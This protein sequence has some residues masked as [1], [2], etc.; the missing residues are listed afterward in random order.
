MNRR[1]Q[2]L[3]KRVAA[4]E[5]LSPLPEKDGGKAPEADV[6]TTSASVSSS[7][8]AFITLIVLSDESRAPNPARNAGDEIFSKTW[9]T[10]SP[11][12][13]CPAGWVENVSFCTVTCGTIMHSSYFLSP[14]VTLR[15][16]GRPP[17]RTSTA[18]ALPTVSLPS[19]EKRSSGSS[20]G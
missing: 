11:D 5:S 15:V 12:R 17:R 3:R 7:N 10:M 13:K 1:G 4:D 20:T 19:A 14:T 9:I 8:E 2:L 18:I 6:I 16:S